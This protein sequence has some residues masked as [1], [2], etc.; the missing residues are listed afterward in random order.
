MTDFL[1]SDTLLYSCLA[2]RER[3]YEQF[4]SEH[5]LTYVVAG[6]IQ[7]QT[8]QGAVWLRP[9]SI[10]LVRRNQLIKTTKVPPVGGGDFKSISAV[11]HQDTLRRYSARQHIQ[12]TGQPRQG[13]VLQEFALDPFLQGYFT[14]LLP[15][16]DQPDQLTGPLMA[17]KTEEA[18]ALLL[19]RDSRL[20]DSLFDFSE[21]G[22]ID[23]EAFMRQHYA[24]NVPLAQFARLTGRSLATFK[25]DFQKLFGQAPQQWVQQQRL[26]QAHYLIAEQ[27][28]APAAVY[29]EVGFINLSHF[30][31]AFKQQFGY[32]ASSLAPKRAALPLAT[33]SKSAVL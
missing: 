19:Q 23:L 30:S 10:W 8:A 29:L 31:L 9:G 17:L 24:Y 27:H 2:A 13:P 20:R 12:P 5:V 7:F 21:P 22:K 3:V 28:Q 33:A 26:A 18:I 1:P 25:R 32:T 14:S 16:F 6:E 11:L 4:V 15:Y